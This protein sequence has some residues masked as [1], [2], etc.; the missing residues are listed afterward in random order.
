MVGLPDLVVIG[1]MKAGTTSV[2]ER[3]ESSS[4][5]MNAGRLKEPDIFVPGSTLNRIRAR[6]ALNFG[7][8]PGIRIDGTTEYSKPH[9]SART[10]E[11]VSTHAPSATIA[12]VVRDPVDRAI[13]HY[14][15]NLERGEEQELDVLKAVRTDGRYLETSQYSKNIAPW[16]ALFGD[17]LH[18]LSAER[19]F[20]GDETELR[21]LADS[22]GVNLS[23]REPMPHANARNS[24]SNL[25]LVRSMKSRLP[26]YGLIRP[27]IPVSLRRSAVKV[28]GRTGSSQPPI[29]TNEDEA[30]EFLANH[31]E[32]ERDW[33]ADKFAWSSPE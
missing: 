6:C 29:A 4:A 22:F 24:R 25:K 19:L 15:H 20:A 13:S 7:S 30:R 31:L 17:N 1:A 21:L 10:A 23:R 26:G 32:G 5:Q 27:L 14:F 16:T 11:L 8:K 18:V 28:V 2:V 9:R 33:I 3:L 12:F